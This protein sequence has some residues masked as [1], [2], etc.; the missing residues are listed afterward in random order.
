MENKLFKHFYSN[1]INEKVRIIIIF[2]KYTEN[3]FKNMASFLKANE[4][5]IILYE[6]NNKLKLG[7]EHKNDI[8]IIGSPLSLEYDEEIFNFF[9]QL[10]SNNFKTIIFEWPIVYY[11]EK[12]RNNLF[13][14]F[15]NAIL[16]DY[17]L[18]R[19][20]NRV[21]YEF[22]KPAKNIEVISQNETKISFKSS[23]N[24][25]CEN[26]NFNDSSIFQIPG[27][28][29]FLVPLV[30]SVNGQI[31]FNGSIIKIRDDYAD[32]SLINSSWNCIPLCEF[33]IGTNIN[34]K[35]IRQLS[36]SEKAFGTCHFGFGNNKNFGGEYERDF[37]FD[38]VIKDFNIFING[39][40]VNLWNQI[41]L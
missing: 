26:C 8:I 9:N 28:E 24:I 14:L 18:L 36:I 41:N 34:V 6:Y 7:Q 15:C 39:K 32:F 13:R 3:F 12:Y 21:L 33:G 35:Y 37:H 27:G 38:I 4:I 20:R 40:E 30:G 17:E 5:N 11:D 1:C 23:G 16:V 19:K 10:E 25:L 31:N 29:V 22:L 2:N